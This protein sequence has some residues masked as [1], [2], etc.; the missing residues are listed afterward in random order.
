MEE[1]NVLRHK[2]AIVGF[3]SSI[4]HLAII[5][6]FV[7]LMPS[8]NDWSGLSNFINGI[9]FIV[10]AF[11]FTIIIPIAYKTLLPR[12]SNNIEWLAVILF[13]ILAI[14]CIINY[15]SCYSIIFPSGNVLNFILN[16]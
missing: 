12:F 4:P 5:F 3:F 1:K 16:R 9:E 14:T 13:F 2:L 11:V 15:I 6:Y 8:G 7:S 10:L